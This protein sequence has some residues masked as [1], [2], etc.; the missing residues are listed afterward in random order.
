[1]RTGRNHE[2][3]VVEKFYVHG[4]VRHRS[5]AAR[6][7]QLDFAPL[8]SAIDHCRFGRQQMNAHTRIS[9]RKSIHDCGN[10]ARANED[11]SP[12][13]HVARS[14]VGEELDVPYRLL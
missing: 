6:N 2:R 3:V 10:E 9:P 1:L 8:E 4:V 12:D 5:R 14:R 11:R 13:P 7:H